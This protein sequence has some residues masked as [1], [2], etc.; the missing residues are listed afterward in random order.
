MANGTA[1]QPTTMPL[2]TM[3]QASTMSATTPPIVAARE[4]GAGTVC[5]AGSGASGTSSQAAM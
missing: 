1:S 5:P 4:R 2:G 3:M